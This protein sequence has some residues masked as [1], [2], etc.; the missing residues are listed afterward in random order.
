MRKS[1]FDDFDID[2]NLYKEDTDN[3]DISDKIDEVLDDEAYD[4]AYDEYAEEFDGRG[5]RILRAASTMM[6]I[7]KKIS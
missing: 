4:E 1:E 7:R 6:S 5:K 3:G 2:M